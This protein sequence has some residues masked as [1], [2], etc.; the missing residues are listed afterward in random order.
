M[1]VPSVNSIVERIQKIQ[2]IDTPILISIDGGSSWIDI[3]VAITGDPVDNP[4]NPVSGFF[5]IVEPEG[6]DQA[7]FRVDPSFG[8]TFEVYWLTSMGITTIPEPS[9][10]VILG[11]ALLVGLS[12]RSR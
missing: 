10:G 11:L 9:S 5:G 4:V 6:F 12:R 2:I 3:S 7:L 1:W 8:S